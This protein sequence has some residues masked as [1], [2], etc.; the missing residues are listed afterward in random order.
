MTTLLNVGQGYV[1]DALSARLLAAGWSVRGTA[2]D[3]AAPIARADGVR[4]FPWPTDATAA[5]DGATHILLSAA[6]GPGGDPVLAAAGQAIADR[7]AGIAWLGYL[8]STGVWGD[9]AGAWVDEDTPPDPDT[10]AGRARLAAET[11][12]TALAARSGLPLHVFRLPGIYGP[13]RGPFDRLRAG[14]ARRVAKPGH[15]TNRMHVADIAATLAASI[16]RPRP[17][18]VYALADDEPAP[19]ED[20]VAFAAGLL[21]MPPPPDEAFATAGL[22]GMAAG[23]YAG[24]KRVRNARIKAELGVA[25]AFPTYREGL[26]AI[27]AAE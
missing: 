4:L 20:V 10:P 14:A 5:L 23:F 19:P 16:A 24:S 7:A 25:L 8:S 3:L 17:G 21:G 27:L 9:H 1:A 6:P 22:T 18:A 2:R 12:W 13:G 11:D 15:V 26:H